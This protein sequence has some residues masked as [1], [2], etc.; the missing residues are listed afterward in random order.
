M[1]EQTSSKA[2][3]RLVTPGAWVEARAIVQAHRYRLALGLLLLLVSRVAGLVLPWMSG[4][5]VDDVIAQARGDLLVPLALAGAAATLVQ[6]STGF[7]L[8]QVLGVAAQRAMHSSSSSQLA[9]PNS[10][11]HSLHQLWQSPQ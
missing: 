2:R 4:Y 8:S 6:A 10:E 5:V 9:A 1:A 7:A 11:M 3:K